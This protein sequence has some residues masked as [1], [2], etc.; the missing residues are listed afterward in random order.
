MYNILFRLNVIFRKA[1]CGIR[2]KPT[3]PNRGNV[4][5]TR[6]SRILKNVTLD[7]ER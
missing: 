6:W 5:R 2:R 7:D 3:S 1:E 4:R